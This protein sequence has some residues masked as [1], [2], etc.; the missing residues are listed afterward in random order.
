M[1]DSGW[2]FE[3]RELTAPH[4]RTLA[5]LSLQP[6]VSLILRSVLVVPRIQEAPPR[7]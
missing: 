6:E 7:R 3:W 2:E 5:A 4:T 1:L